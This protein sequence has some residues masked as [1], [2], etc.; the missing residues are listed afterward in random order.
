[1]IKAKCPTC[2]KKTVPFILTVEDGDLAVGS[3]PCQTCRSELTEE[4]RK[5]KI[6]NLVDSI[7]RKSG[8]PKVEAFTRA[9]AL[10]MPVCPSTD[11]P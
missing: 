11:R 10:M 7:M 4:E 9:L 2:G 6:R 1:M 5:E 3:K 8:A